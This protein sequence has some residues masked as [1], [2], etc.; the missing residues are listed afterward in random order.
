M[1]LT[2]AVQ[3][4]FRKYVDFSGRAVRSEYWYWVLAVVLG[5]LVLGVVDSVMFASMAGP[6]GV[7]P[8][9]LIYS[10]AVFLPSL[11]VA[12]RRLH[13]VGR[14]GWWYLIVFV[15]LIGLLV[16]LYWFVQPGSDGANEYGPPPQVTAV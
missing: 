6:G 13:D 9:S 2:E 11:A 14:S 5:S 12:V 15:P 3:T 10:L 7:Q 16:L 8:L 1:N 4:G